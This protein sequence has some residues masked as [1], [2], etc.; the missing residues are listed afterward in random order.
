MCK[1]MLD[2]CFKL[3]QEKQVKEGVKVGRKNKVCWVV[4][5]IIKLLD[6]PPQIVGVNKLGSL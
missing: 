4:D 1:M 2:I 6:G 3:V 5:K